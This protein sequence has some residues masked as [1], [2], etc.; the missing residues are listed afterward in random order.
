MEANCRYCAPVLAC[1][2]R[3]FPCEIRHQQPGETSLMALLG[4]FRTD[5][6]IG[7]LVSESDTNSAATQKLVER[8]KKIGPKVIPKIID[9]LAMSDKTHTMLFVDILASHVNDHG[10][11]A[12]QQ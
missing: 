12:L 11:G 9:A 4:G 2:K 7:Q 10:V 8:L 6:L 3:R 1:A 5:Q